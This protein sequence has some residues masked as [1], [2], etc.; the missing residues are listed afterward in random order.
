MR[1]MLEMRRLMRSFTALSLSLAGLLMTIHPAAAAGKPLDAAGNVA[2]V[3]FAQ[4][5]VR[6]AGAV[7]LFD[8]T[9]HD[10]LSGTFSGTSVIEGSCMVQ[11]SGQAVCTATETLTGTVAG[12][13]GTAEFHDVVFLDLATSAFHGS[14]TVVGGTGGLASLHGQGTFEGANGRG[15][16]TGNVIFAP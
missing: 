10:A 8:F 12:R 7:T 15:T 2:Q 5:N 4:S 13:A 9:E 1:P 16:Y 6:T 11:A 14:F 3:S